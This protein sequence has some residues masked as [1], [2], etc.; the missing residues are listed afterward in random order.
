MDTRYLAAEHHLERTNYLEAFDLYL[1][2]EESCPNSP[3]GV[4]GIASILHRLGY[5]QE[6]FPFY[7]MAIERSIDNESILF[8]Y[9]TDLADVY[10]ELGNLE[11]A[12]FTINWSKQINPDHD[13]TDI[14]MNKIYR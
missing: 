4:S 11:F 7:I 10:Y 12:K 3:F 8:Y 2:V 1:Q 9:L 13:Y 5:Y 14:I 6:S